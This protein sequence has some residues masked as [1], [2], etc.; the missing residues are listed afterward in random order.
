[1]IRNLSPTFVSPSLNDSYLLAHSDCSSGVILNL[2]SLFDLIYFSDLLNKLLNGRNL[3]G[4][5]FGFYSSEFQ[6]IYLVFETVGF[7]GVNANA[8]RNIYTVVAFCAGNKVYLQTTNELFET[9]FWRFEKMTVFYAERCIKGII[10]KVLVI[11][12]LY[13][14][15][16]IILHSCFQNWI[17]LG[18]LNICIKRLH[19]L[20]F[21]CAIEI[22]KHQT[23][24][25]IWNFDRSS[26]SSRALNIWT[27][28]LVR[29]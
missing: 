16:P 9:I 21:A 28:N 29:R 4:I 2:I 14:V 3:T 27:C 13:T 15:Y 25:W 18:H 5:F 1:M 19:I 12:L 24:A 20:N 6:V 23:K 10:V 11:A 8:I 26:Y 22:R 7:C 17:F